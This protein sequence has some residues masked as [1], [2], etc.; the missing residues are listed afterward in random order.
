M[1]KFILSAFTDEYSKMFDEQLVGMAENGLKFMEIRG[2]D[3][4]NI[5]DI[6]V[7]KA[8]E[9]KVKLDAHGMGVSSMGSPIGKIKVDDPMEPHIEQLKHVC[10]LAHTLNCDRIRMFSFYYPKEEPAEN[11]RSVVMDRLGQMLKVA[12]AENI[13]LCHENEK[14]IYGDI[15]TRCLD[16]QK[17]FNSEIKLVFDHANFI[18][19]D[20]EPFPKAY[21]MLKDYIYYMHIKDATPAKQM[22]PAGEGIGR[23]PETIKE[24][25]KFDKTF[26]L[27]AEPHL[28]VFSGL[29][30]LEGDNDLTFERQYASSAEAFKV[31]IDAIKKCVAD[32]QG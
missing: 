2:V 27:T 5:A 6:T 17:E 30:K 32:A 19:C 29:D 24:L 11:Y 1:A 9:L 23:I 28:R 7:D 20:D 22:A 13:T 4:T 14:G 21:E 16:I 31:A 8:K 26:Y 25:N 18:C 15:A 3:G 10:E 12:Q